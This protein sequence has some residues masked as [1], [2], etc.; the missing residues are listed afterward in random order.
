MINPKK[1]PPPFPEREKTGNHKKVEKPIVLQYMLISEEQR[2]KCFFGC[3]NDPILKWIN[4][5]DKYLDL[6]HAKQQ[7]EKMLRSHSW[8]KDR[9]TKE[10]LW[11]LYDKATDT[12]YTIAIS[13]DNIVTIEEK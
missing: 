1:V 13:E 3:Y 11:R 8:M 12:E 10:R 2:A 7:L 4:Y 6:K 5:Y 9:L